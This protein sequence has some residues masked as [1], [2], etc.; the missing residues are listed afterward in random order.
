MAD[1]DLPDYHCDDDDSLLCYERGDPELLQ[2]DASD[3]EREDG[4]FAPAGQR[5]RHKETKRLYF[6]EPGGPDVDSPG[7]GDKL[8]AFLEQQPVATLRRLQQLHGIQAINLPP[9]NAAYI[10]RNAWNYPDALPLGSVSPRVLTA[11]AIERAGLG[12]SGPD[13]KPSE[14]TMAAVEAILLLGNARQPMP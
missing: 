4:P 14:E 7:F 5:W 8:L 9:E 10:L 6:G 11:L 2:F 1:D 13:G 3:F 12:E